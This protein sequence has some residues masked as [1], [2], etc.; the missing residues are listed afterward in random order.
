MT[1]LAAASVVLIAGQATAGGKS[2]AR[3]VPGI[4]FERDGDL[5]AVTVDSRRTVRLTNTP[6]WSEEE[7]AVSPD[8]RSIAYS[9]SWNGP[10]TIWI[11]SV[12]GRRARRLTGGGD[13]SP[14]WSPDAR[15]IY[16]D[17]SVKR[18]PEWCG[19]IF[20][21]RVDGREV[22]EQVTRPS[23]FHSHFEPSVS[24]DGYRIAF[25]DANQCSG[26]T[27]A[28]A[29]T[30]V[31]RF[32]RETGDLAH[33]PGNNHSDSDPFFESPSW[34]PDGTRMALIKDIHA[35]SIANV[36]GSG[37]RTITRKQ[38]AHSDPPAWSPDSQWI[39][40]TSQRADLWVIR[41]DGTDLRRLTHTKA[42]EFHPSWLPRMP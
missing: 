18:G 19:A 34:S 33:L 42:Y 24:P 32:E 12:D 30:V 4:V 36:D 8:G 29:V 21:K 7:P 41:A 10:R 25:T 16:F 22:A 38:F 15:F 23:G 11:M 40:F 14:A 39:A 6:V 31:D 28:Y 3:S 20:R 1:V 9:R 2:S 27:A 26:G 5:Y 37:L 17:R 13:G 35:L